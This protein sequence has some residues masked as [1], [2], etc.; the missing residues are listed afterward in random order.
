MNALAATFP[1]LET[2]RLVLREFRLDEAD[3]A[4]L[5][6]IFSDGRVT[7]FYNLKTFTEP[8]E[9]QR[10]LTKR[11]DR[12]W[13]GRGVRWAIVPRGQDELIGSCG[14]NELNY[15]KKVGELGY[16]LARPYWQRGIMTEAVS[17]IISYGLA[18]LPMERIEA[19]VMPQNRASANLL[20]KLGFQSEGVLERKGYWDGRFHDL[21]LFSLLAEQWNL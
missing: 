17:A 20:L 5:F 10:L 14:F 19:W 6:R 2:E 12:F 18:H 9:A 21:E 8:D 7:R 13:Q 3:R 15:K 16:E 1:Q 4:A 11:H